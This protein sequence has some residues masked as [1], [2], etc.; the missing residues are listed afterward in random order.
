MT[1]P[2]Q[3]AL[4]MIGTG[5]EE[6]YTMRP[7]AP[8]MD[9]PPATLGGPGFA[10]A[11]RRVLLATRP[12]FFT[13]SVLPVAVGTA[14]A[15]ARLHRFD[16]VLALLA[17]AGTVLAHAATNVYNDVGDDITGADPG[18][19]DRI[20]P[21]TGGSRFIQ[22][23]L[24]SRGGMVRIALGLAVAA[25][26]VGVALA[27]LRG[28]GVIGLGLAGLLLGLLYSL[29]G[30]QLSARGVGEAAVGV[31]LGALP[32]LGAV[33]L[34]AGRVDLGAVLVSLPVT[35]WVTAILLINEVPDVEPDRRAGKRTL[36]VRYGARGARVIYAGLTTLALA[37]A[38]AAALCG[39]LPI[40]YLVPAVA[41]AA[42]GA[43]AAAGISMRPEDR[44]RLTRSIQSTLAVHTLGC[45]VL[46]V[47][48]LTSGLR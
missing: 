46:T 20:Y 17:L 27:V 3:K 15:A 25:L 31:G 6:V 29:P 43:M 44:P 12:A 40:W 19:N 24:I 5:P 21:F 35:A 33:W 47:A 8:R 7:A 16:T 22:T 39:A 13:A 9:A 23:G 42:L 14:W 2:W 48:V 38:V 32:V 10:A 26:G 30:V 28:P 11:A 45:I 34:Q 41:L 1:L 18:N 36:V 37:A 4:I